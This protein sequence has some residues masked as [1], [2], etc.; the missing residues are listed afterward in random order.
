MAN[1]QDA[2]RPN[3]PLFDA[4]ALALR[5]GRARRRQT[6]GTPFLLQR[7]VA[8]LAERLQDVNR[9]FS[10]AAL[11]GPFDWRGAITDAVPT[12]KRPGSF[13]WHDAPQGGD[14]D[15]VISL[16]HLQ[17]VETV[18]PWM[19]GARAMLRPDGLFI[20]CLVG[21]Q[22]LAGL[23]QALYTVDTD[24]RG[25]PT[26]RVHPMI[27]VRAA[28][29]LLGHAGLAIPVTDS[30]RFTVSYRK[31]ETLAADLRDLGLSNALARRDRTP[32]PALLRTLDRHMR[33]APGQPIPIRWELVWMTGWAPHESQQTP[34]KPGSAKTPLN[35]ALRKIRDQSD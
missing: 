24:A 17:S 25:A 15:L 27:E 5:I 26:P 2:S 14:Y 3:E 35:A 8:D 30:D 11:I 4:D 16:L 12:S 23:R 34:L 7:A 9:T 13:D 19:Q 31:L 1:P 29:Q 28:A 6:R 10:R 22:S 21:G 18:G 32:A 20:A 33:P